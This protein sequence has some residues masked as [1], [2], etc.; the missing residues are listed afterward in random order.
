MPQGTIYTRTL[1]A[2][3][4]GP[5]RSPVVSDRF[6]IGI[7][8]RFARQNFPLRGKLEIA[9][10]RD[11]LNFR[12]AKILSRFARRGASRHEAQII[13][14]AS[15]SGFGALCAL[16]FPNAPR[17]GLGRASRG[18]NFRCAE[19]K[20]RDFKNFASRNFCRAPRDAALRAAWYNLYSDGFALGSRLASLAVIR[21]SRGSARPRSAGPGFLGLFILFI[22]NLF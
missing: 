14:S 4:T 7:E 22:F 2:R 19:I 12:S 21:A 18:R 6:A 13:P 1:R 15:H 5:L 9:L 16:R 10:P 17:S 11:F 3:V 20:S 8:P